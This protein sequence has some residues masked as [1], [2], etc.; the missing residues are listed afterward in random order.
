MICETKA[1]DF[2]AIN[3]DAMSFDAFYRVYFSA[4]D[5]GA[6]RLRHWPRLT[7]GIKRLIAFALPEAEVWVQVRSGLSQGMWMRLHLPREARLWRGEHEVTVQHSILAV[8]RPGVVVYDIGAHA[9]SLALGMARLV[10]PQGC[11]V[12]FEADPGNVENL[13]ENSLRNHLAASLQIVP[14]SVWSHSAIDIPF[15]RGGPQRTQGGVE[16]DGQHPVLGSG[17]VIHVP[18]VT[19]DDFIANGGPIPQMIKIDV[20]GGEFEVLRGGSNLFATRRPLIVAE[21]HHSQAAEQIGAWLTEYRYIARWIV[22]TEGFPRCLLAWPEG[23]D[24]ADWM[25]RT[26]HRIPN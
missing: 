10:G 5:L 15:R 4:R 17:D 6:A 24:G 8:V 3:F 25:R 11:V 13:K 7:S 9:G 21:V 23:Y 16:S 14:S 26:D 18:A 20:E 12:A 19:L 2:A 1:R 22:P